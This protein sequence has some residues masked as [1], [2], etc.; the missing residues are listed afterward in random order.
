MTLDAPD[1]G[2]QLEVGSSFEIEWHIHIQ[3]NTQDWDLW[4]STTSP[5][6]PWIPVGVG[7]HFGN[8]YVGLVGSAAGVHLRWKPAKARPP[9]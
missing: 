5:E 7:V 6:G 3:H 1:G 2:E 9:A 4:Y 8:A